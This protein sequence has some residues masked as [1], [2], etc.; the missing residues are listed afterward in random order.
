MFTYFSAKLPNFLQSRTI[1]LV[2]S[3]TFAV[4]LLYQQCL[5]VLF[6][7]KVKLKCRSRCVFVVLAQRLF[8]VAVRARNAAAR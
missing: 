3:A 1:Y 6:L 4:T 7:R 2:K 8:F 5:L